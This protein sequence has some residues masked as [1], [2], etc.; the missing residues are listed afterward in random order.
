MWPQWTFI[1]LL[2]L[3]LGIALGKDGQP[4]GN[5]SFWASLFNSAITF[6]IL[7]FGGFFKGMF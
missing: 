2:I 3:G 1:V 5:W 7:Y 6:V 4:R